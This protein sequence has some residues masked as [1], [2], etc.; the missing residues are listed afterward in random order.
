MCKSKKE[1]HSVIQAKIEEAVKC[2]MSD[3]EIVLNKELIVILE[4][5]KLDSGYW[6]EYARTIFFLG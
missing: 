6:L 5:L 4:E 2:H 3:I 1:H